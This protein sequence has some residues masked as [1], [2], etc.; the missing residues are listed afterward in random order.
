[1]VGPQ[2]RGLC[3]KPGVNL[4]HP[5]ELDL[6]PRMASP[7]LSSYS[8]GQQTAQQPLLAVEGVSLEAELLQK[9]LLMVK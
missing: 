9:L 1:M 2:G 8:L 7:H 6:Q 4:Y 5:P 3:S